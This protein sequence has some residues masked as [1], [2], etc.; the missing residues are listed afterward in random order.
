MSVL[1]MA[2][3]QMVYD[4]W[5][6]TPNDMR[7]HLP[8]LRACASGLSVELGC[9]QGISTAALLAGAEEIGGDAMVVSVSTEDVGHLFRGHPHWSFLL[10]DSTDQ[11]TVAAFQEAFPGR[12]IDTL[13]LD[14]RH[15]Y[16]HV[17]AE[18][19][20]WSPLMRSGGVVLVHDTVYA[21]GVR[22]AVEAHAARTG[23]PTM[24][25]LPDNGLAFMVVH[26]AYR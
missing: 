26:H 16:A 18:L 4:H 5:L 17:S 23:W 2:S 7:W 21:P 24:Y 15:T 22:R 3:A 11:H 12:L 19:T 1:P 14:S 20:I 25:L 13:V 9:S 8:L 10:G 6:R